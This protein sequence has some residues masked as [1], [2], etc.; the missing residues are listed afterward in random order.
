MTEED[1][2]IAQLQG[3]ARAPHL[4]IEQMTA[5]EITDKRVQGALASLLLSLEE[6]G[7]DVEDPT[8]E[9]SVPLLLELIEMMVGEYEHQKSNPKLNVIRGLLGN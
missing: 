8:I 3:L 2:I 1:K 7:V 9:V 4:P 5:E 6:D